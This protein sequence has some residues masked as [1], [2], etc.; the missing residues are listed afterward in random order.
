MLACIDVN[1]NNIFVLASRNKF[2]I[3]TNWNAFK[4]IC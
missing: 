4:D 3:W 2:S 1:L